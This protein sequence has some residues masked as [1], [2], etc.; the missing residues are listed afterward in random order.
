MFFVRDPPIYPV[1]H[2]G[3]VPDPGRFDT[4]LNPR[5]RTTGFRVRIRFCSSV[6]FKMSTVKIF[7]GVFFS[8][9]PTVVIY[10][11]FKITN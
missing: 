9:L 5:I 8:L 1:S 4:D 6:A 2:L 7:H 11:K 3:I 10:I